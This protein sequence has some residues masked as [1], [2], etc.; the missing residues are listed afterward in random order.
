[1]NANSFNLNQLNL[2]SRPAFAFIQYEEEGA[3]EAAVK[4]ENGTHW[5]DKTIRVSFREVGNDSNASR[6]RTPSTPFGVSFYAAAANA[7]VNAAM[8]TISNTTPMYP[9]PP[10][11]Q[12]FLVDPHANR[13]PLPSPP[14][15]PADNPP[16]L[17]NVGRFGSVRKMIS[18]IYIGKAFT[19]N[20][21]NLF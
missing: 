19:K 16:Y 1:M 5:L 21:A 17:A 10:Y 6:N 2:D 13:Y 14:N 8:N 3:A 11:G 9:P 15:S 7:A 12:A 20:W 4:N 18:F